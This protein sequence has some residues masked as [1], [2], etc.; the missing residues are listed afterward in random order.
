MAERLGRCERYRCE[1]DAAGLF[2]RREDDRQWRLCEEHAIEQM[3][4][5]AG[6]LLGDLG[7]IIENLAHMARVSVHSAPGGRLE[8]DDAA[9]RDDAQEVPES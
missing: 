7:G 1:A 8:S 6:E 4:E 3:E 2:Y 5:V 9:R